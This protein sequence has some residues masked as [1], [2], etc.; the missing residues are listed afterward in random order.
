MF[1]FQFPDIDFLLKS[2]LVIYKTELAALTVKN[3]LTV[4][5]WAF[6]IVLEAFII[7]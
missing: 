7:D 4:T 3:T 1:A 2:Y 6:L 5:K